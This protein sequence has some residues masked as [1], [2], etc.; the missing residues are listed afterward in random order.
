MPVSRTRRRR[1][2]RLWFP[3]TVL[4]AL[5]LGAAAWA[6]GPSDLPPDSR[7][8]AADSGTAA[9]HPA[10]L[11]RPAAGEHRVAPLARRRGDERRATVARRAAARRGAGLVHVGPRLQAQPEPGV[12][13]LGHRPARAHAAASAAR[14]PRRASRRPRGSA[15]A[16]SRAGTAGPST[17]ASAGSG[18]PPTRTGSTSTS[19]TR[20]ATGAS[21]ARTSPARSIA[22]SPRT[23]STA[24][25]AAGAQYLF[26]GPRVGPAR[27]PRRGL[28]ARQPRRPRARPA[29][30]ACSFAG[31]R[32]VSGSPVSRWPTRSS[33]KWCR[34]PPRTTAT[35]GSADGAWPASHPGLRGPDLFSRSNQVDA[36]AGP[37]SRLRAPRP[38]LR[39]VHGLAVP[40][41]GPAE[42]DPRSPRRTA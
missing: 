10:A 9:V 32:T 27:P 42:E 31:L 40:P 34:S 36:R 5:V 22:C 4:L 28:P 35:I 30:Q 38:R 16:T 3:A 1:Q 41:A 18:T 20:A 15:S 6:S 13:S 23:S 29:A 14:V 24:S 25:R 11:Q 17:G 19:T 21:C 12:A 7:S 33:S 26:V 37:D 2:R 8:R 39:A